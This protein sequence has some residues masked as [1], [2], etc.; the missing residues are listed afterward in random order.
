MNSEIKCRKCGLNFS[1]VTEKELEEILSTN[2]EASFDV[3][4]KDLDVE[5][6]KKEIDVTTSE[7]LQELLEGLKKQEEI[8]LQIEKKINKI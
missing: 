7:L 1:N 4:E 3:L 6:S 8:I 5:N 2:S